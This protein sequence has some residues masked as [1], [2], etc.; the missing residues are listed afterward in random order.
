MQWDQPVAGVSVAF[1]DVLPEIERIV[2]VV[3][4]EIWMGIASGSQHVCVCVCV[5]G[6]K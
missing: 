6:G 5:G 3:S 2:A 4:K 1:E